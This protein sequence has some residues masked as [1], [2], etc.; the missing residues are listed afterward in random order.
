MHYQIMIRVLSI[1]LGGR[2]GFVA[3]VQPID[4]TGTDG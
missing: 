2:S 4:N 3:S 1:V